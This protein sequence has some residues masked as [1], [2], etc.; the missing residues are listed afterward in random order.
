MRLPGAYEHICTLSEPSSRRYRTGPRGRTFGS[1]VRSFRCSAR[2]ALRK[3]AVGPRTF[4]EEQPNEPELS[5]HPLCCK[6]PSFHMHNGLP[7]SAARGGTCHSLLDGKAYCSDAPR[8]P[9]SGHRYSG[10][11]RG[12]NHRDALPPWPHSGMTQVKSWHREGKAQGGTLQGS[13]EGH[14][15]ELGRRESCRTTWADRHT[16]WSH[17]LRGHSSNSQGL[18]PRCTVGKA[19]GGRARGSGEGSHD[20][21][22]TRHRSCVPESE[23]FDQ[24]LGPCC[25][26]KCTVAWVRSGDSG[27]LDKPRQIRGH[28]SHLIAAPR[29]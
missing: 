7:I 11:R 6:T 12:R 24:V 19:Q 23:G 20:P 15:S 1:H 25:R 4:P 28:Q 16:W 18:Q 17:W 5:W 26:S 10:T 29:D 21:S 22:H 8:N 3:E 27:S 9:T 2:R 14:S 13:C